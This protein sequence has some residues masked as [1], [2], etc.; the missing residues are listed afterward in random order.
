MALPP[1]FLL[2]FPHET[3]CPLEDQVTGFQALLPHATCSPSQ[4]VPPAGP[5]TWR[6]GP[7]LGPRQTSPNQSRLASFL[8]PSA[9]Q[10]GTSA[11]SWEVLSPKGGTSPGRVTDSKEQAGFSASS[12]VGIPQDLPEKDPAWEHQIG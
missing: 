7:D 6:P 10:L 2:L 8:H 4:G 5:L 3:V 9:W 11:H 1:L 12:H